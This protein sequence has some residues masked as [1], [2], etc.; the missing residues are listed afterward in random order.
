[1]AD[2]VRSFHN[3]SSISEYRK[4][5]IAQ[6]AAKI[7]KGEILFFILSSRLISGILI[8]KEE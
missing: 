8:G 4:T 5:S 1:M 7:K 3:L 6:F 2:D